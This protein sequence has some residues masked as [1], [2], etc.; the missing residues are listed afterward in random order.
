MR[1]CYCTFA[2]TEAFPVKVNVQLG[3]LLP[4]QAP[5]QIAT[6]PSLR[7]SVTRLPE[8]NEADPVLPTGTLIPEGLEV[9]RIPLLPLA[10]TVSVA[11]AGAGAGGFSVSTAERVTPP[12]ETAIV[13][14]VRLVTDEVEMLNLA[15]VAPAGI[16]SEFGTV[17]DGLLL[18]TWK[19]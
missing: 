4:T 11:V 14:W 16:N 8:G 19:I 13:P 2:L 9:T 6:R 7:F 5:V 1:K 3:V 15:E 12:P 18:V 17:M 10:V